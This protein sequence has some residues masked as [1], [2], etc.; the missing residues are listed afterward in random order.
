M[1]FDDK[2]QMLRG[3]LEF[4]DR[5]VTQLTKQ[6]AQLIS[7]HQGKTKVYVH[8]GMVFMKKRSNMI[9]STLMLLRILSH[10]SSR[11]RGS[12]EYSTH[13]GV[14]PLS[15]GGEFEYRTIECALLLLYTHGRCTY[16]ATA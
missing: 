13:Y 14:L 11:G 12:F 3:R 4:F 6:V 8:A 10:V 15:A 7:H 16:T 9:M 5:N 1:A 2:G